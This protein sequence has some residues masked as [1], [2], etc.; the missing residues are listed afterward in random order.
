MNRQMCNLTKLRLSPDYCRS[1][2][3]KRSLSQEVASLQLV[4]EMRNSEIRTIQEKNTGL[5]DKLED[6]YA[7]QVYSLQGDS[8]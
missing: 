1:D 8:P 2:F 7:T 6:H 3:R 5:M 4:V